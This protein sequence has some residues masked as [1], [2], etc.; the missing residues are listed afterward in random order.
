MEFE[1][2]DFI[3]SGIVTIAEIRKVAKESNLR[4]LSKREK[5]KLNTIRN[6]QRRDRWL[7][8]RLIAKFL[9]LNRIHLGLNAQNKLWPPNLYRLNQLNF[10]NYSAWMYQQTEILAENSR[11]IGAPCII[12][13]GNKQELSISLSYAE[14]MSVV[15]IGSIG[16]VGLDI[17]LV[18]HRIDSFYRYNFTDTERKWVEEYQRNYKVNPHWLFT[19]LWTIKESWIKSLNSYYSGIWDF[20]KI[21][22]NVASPPEMICALFFKKDFGF[23]LKKF[24]VE[25]NENNK[26]IAVLVAST[27]N[28]NV[29]LTIIKLIKEV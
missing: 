8:S 28:E 13:C 14:G 11:Q 25:I 9:F 24:H 26:R 27:A 5:N 21:E 20:L 4:F 1:Q 19:F 15:F 3:F 12:W 22:I 16:F 2:T 18:Q 6:K 29:I 17:E 10:E 23:K 7:T